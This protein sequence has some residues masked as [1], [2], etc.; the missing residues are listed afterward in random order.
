M[1]PGCLCLSQKASCGGGI[2]EF[3]IRGVKGEINVA[4][5]SQSQLKPVIWFHEN[6]K[7]VG[8]TIIG[9]RDSDLAVTERSEENSP[10]QESGGMNET[11]SAAD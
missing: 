7:I 5:V 6:S 3:N 10:R 9:I 2:G 4:P 8:I 1:N 11:D